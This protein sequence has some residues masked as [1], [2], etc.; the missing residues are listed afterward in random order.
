[1]QNIN[2]KAELEKQQEFVDQNALVAEAKSILED[3]VS[4]EHSI[5]QRITE[6]T[7]GTS[8]ESFDHSRLDKARIFD[9]EAIERLCT[10]F[11]LRFLDS[12]LF[13]GEIPSEA[14]H[15][16]RHI[17]SNI[18]IKFSTFKVVAPSERFRLKDSTKDP[19]LLAELPNGRHY[20]IYQWGDDM[21]WYQSILKYPMRHFGT[22]T[23]SALA[24]GALITVLMPTQFEQGQA[25]FFYRFFLFSM[26]SALILT[27]VLITGI[28]Y[29]KDFSE[30]IWN[31]KFLK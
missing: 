15:Q 24:L 17:E 18:G 10:K 16:I 19:I 7:L 26:S 2:L 5:A 31:S 13:K 29:S 1:M 22:L 8:S 30:N 3:N 20:F 14:I 21:K 4:R 28:M 23:M 12:T 11:R 25:E 27:L 6:G 9:T